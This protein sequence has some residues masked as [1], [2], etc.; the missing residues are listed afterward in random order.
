MQ[1]ITPLP[2]K[3]MTRPATPPNGQLTPRDL[4]ILRALDRFRFLSS[5]QIAE[6]VGGSAQ[7]VL[8][9]LQFLFYIGALTRPPQQHLQL[10]AFPDQGNR[11]LIYGLDAAGADRLAQEDPSISRRDWKVRNGQASNFFLQHTI[12][13]ADI[14]LAFERACRERGD[15]ELIDQQQLRPHFPQATLDLKHPL[16]L[17]LEIPRQRKPPIK[18]TVAPDRLIAVRRIKDKAALW[19]AIENDL[20]TMEIAGSGRARYRRKLN[21]YYHATRANRHTAQWGCKQSFRVLTVTPSLKR[22]EHMIEAQREVTNDSVPG[23][24]AYNTPERIAEHGALAA[25][26]ITSKHPEGIS[27]VT[28]LVA[29]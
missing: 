12:S 20:A 24:F 5:A 2:L 18:T 26:W 1:T 28:A 10:A 15:L 25:T 23:L 3:R 22:I 13:T 17:R 4:N 7:G 6:L 11:P 16:R 21:A 29:S 27:L 14:V 8:R 19:F 9:R